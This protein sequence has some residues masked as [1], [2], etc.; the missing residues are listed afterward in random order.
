MIR[1]RRRARAPGFSLVE[2]L[3]TLAI[4]AVLSGVLYISSI[5]GHR[6]YVTGD[7]YVHIQ[8]QA[9]QAMDTMHRELHEAGGV[10]AAA[11]AQL[12]FQAALG[13][14]LA[15][16]CPVDAVCWGA[17]DAAGTNQSGWSVRYRL[18]GTQLVREIL[19]AAA[20]VQST[21]VLANDVSQLAFT[22]VGGTTRTVTVSIQ[23]RR[24]S[25]ELAGGSL[26]VAPTPLITTIKLRNT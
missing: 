11:G 22:Y 24:T 5:V 4:F 26:S 3:V 1:I 21:R 2:L 25:A 20:V 15:A 14:N 10:I 12:T 9:R 23:V 8:Q 19:N 6:S 7:S 17:R 16:P 18:S 13:Y